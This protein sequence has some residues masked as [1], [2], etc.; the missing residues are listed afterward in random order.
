MTSGQRIR[1]VYVRP[2]F[3]EAGRGGDLH[4]CPGGS[5]RLDDGEFPVGSGINPA[6]GLLA[7][8]RFF[9]LFR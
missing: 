7:K 4:L 1:A 8:V 3:R 9:T 5:R 6:P 2:L